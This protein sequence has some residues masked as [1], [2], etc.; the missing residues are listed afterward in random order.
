VRVSEAHQFN[1]SIYTVTEE[2]NVAEDFLKLSE[3]V[4]GRLNTYDV[5]MALEQLG[6]EEKV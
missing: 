6:V 1:K 4:I 5:N 2:S 3:E